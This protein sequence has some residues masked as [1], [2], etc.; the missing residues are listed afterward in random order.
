M[1][2]VDVLR[3]TFDGPNPREF[4]DAQTGQARAGGLSGREVGGFRG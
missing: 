4:R 1:A 2:G 3:E